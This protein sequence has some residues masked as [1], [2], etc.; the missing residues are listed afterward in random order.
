M[1][2]NCHR[3]ISTET[4]PTEKKKFFYKPHLSLC[5]LH[6]YRLGTIV[7]ITVKPVLMRHA[8]RRQRVSL[9]VDDD[10]HNDDENDDAEQE[11]LI[12]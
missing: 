11:L 4:K 1:K 3:K 2:L 10:D 8:A 7:L 5:C 12:H 6:F 9:A